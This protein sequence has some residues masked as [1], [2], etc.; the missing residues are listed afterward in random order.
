MTMQ[1]V[2][3]VMPVEPFKIVMVTLGIAALLASLFFLG[4]QLFGGAIHI[5]DVDS[6]SIRSLGAVLWGDR[7]LDMLCQGFLVFIGAL[8][9]FTLMSGAND[10]KFPERA[11]QGEHTEV[12]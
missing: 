5:G 2:H 10:P 12:K 3:P 4:G 7:A 9:A 1:P 11:R 6:F 8:G